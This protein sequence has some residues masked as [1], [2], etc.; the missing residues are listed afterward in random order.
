VKVI[1]TKHGGFAAGI[2]RRPQVLDSGTLAE[3]ESR[4]LSG[5]AAALK[6][7][8]PVEN[9]GPGRARDAMSYTITLEEGERSDVFL[10]SDTNMSPEFNDLLLWLERRS[11]DD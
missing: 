5:L 7:T 9:E 4:E 3:I 11:P 1:L 10:Q 6:A 2:R 8:R